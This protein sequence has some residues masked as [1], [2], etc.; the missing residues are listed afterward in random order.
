MR[1]ILIAAGILMGGAVILPSSIARARAVE[2]TGRTVYVSVVDNKGVPVGDLTAATY[3]ARSEGF[4]LLGERPRTPQSS[5][6]MLPKSVT[7]F[8]S[9]QTHSGPSASVR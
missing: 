7:K 2:P 8:S 4:P 6:G 1:R 5:R 9:T 3:V